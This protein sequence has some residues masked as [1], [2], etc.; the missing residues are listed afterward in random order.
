MWKYTGTVLSS[1]ISATWQRIKD[2]DIDSTLDTVNATIQDK[3]GNYYGAY[4]PT[5]GNEPAKNWN[6][7]A[8]REAH[9]GDMFYNTLTGYAYRYAVTMQCMKVT[10]SEDSRT[11]GASYDWVQIFYELD[12]KT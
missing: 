11:E 5:T 10:F 2:S 12:G 3:S 6:T 9:I 4:A 8:K 7:N 1:S